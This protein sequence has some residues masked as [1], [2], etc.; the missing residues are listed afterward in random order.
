[1][2]GAAL[3]LVGCH[4]TTGSPMSNGSSGDRLEAAAV[5]AGLV[6]DPAKRSLTGSWGRDTDRACVV[7]R[8]G[9]DP[10]LGVLVDYGAG[11]GCVAR[12][13]VRRRG[14][15]LDVALPGC[16]FT[17]RFDGGRIAFPA[18]LPAPCERLC[19]GRA[20][21]AAL[22]VEALGGSASEAAL[23]RAP[24]GQLLCGS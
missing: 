7:P 4:D 3:L 2:V 24:D 6:I 13:T 23:L 17:A 16:R 8:D 12:G 14:E 11:Q 9:A 1:M 20:S 18:E 21:L 19:T 10:R 22:S 5:A 15:I